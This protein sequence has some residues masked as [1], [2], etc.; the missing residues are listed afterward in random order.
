MKYEISFKEK[1]M[2]IVACFVTHN[3]TRAKVSYQGKKKFSDVVEYI[4]S[5]KFGT[6]IGSRVVTDT[7]NGSLF[8]Y[9]YDFGKG[10]S[11]RVCI[12]HR[13]EL[14]INMEYERQSEGSIY[15]VKN[16]LNIMDEKL[17]DYEV[18]QEEV[19]EVKT[20]DYSGKSLQELIEIFDKNVQQLEQN[21]TIAGLLQIDS[22]KN[23]IK[24]KINEKPL[25]ERAPFNQ[26]ISQIT[27]YI[28]A[29]KMQFNMGNTQFVGT[30]V[31]QISASLAELANLVK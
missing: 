20:I 15:T 3:I 27:T 1:F 26:P 5:G 25:A 22:I 17:K 29:L 13:G 7:D 2:Y 19:I 16:H 28:D 21:P 18:E 31:P 23:N 9:E 8:I 6:D 12:Q 30:Y 11:F 4:K 10:R 14:L 24:S